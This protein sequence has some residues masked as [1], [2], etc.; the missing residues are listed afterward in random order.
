TPTMLEG[1]VS[2]NVTPP[3]AKAIL[4]VRSTPVWTHDELEEALRSR[5]SSEV[6]VTSKRLVPCETP[7]GSRLLDALRAASPDATT[8]RSPPCSDWCFL[9]DLDAVKFGP[10][11]S[12]RSHTPDECVDIAEVTAARSLYASVAERYLT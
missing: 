4:D 7:A 12:R 9:R 10:G 8:Y 6:V 5:L 1:G 2:R 11:T 3:V